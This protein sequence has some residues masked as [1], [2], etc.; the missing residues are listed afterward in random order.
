MSDDKN[1]NS[2]AAPEEEKKESL[3][4]KIF[5]WA[6]LIGI[7]VLIANCVGGFQAKQKQKFIAGVKNTALAACKESK[8]CI[9]NVNRNFDI[10]L[11]G[12]L[13]SHKTGRFNRKYD[14]D[15]PVFDMCMKAMYMGK[16]MADD[17]SATPTDSAPAGANTQGAESHDSSSE[18]AAK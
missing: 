7:A 6:V 5:Q 14:L 12:S 15:K 11:Q 17:A 8:E 9:D 2:D 16:R 13:D 10:C 1:Q 18:A 4:S 3:K